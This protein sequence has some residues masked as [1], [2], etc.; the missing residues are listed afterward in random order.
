MTPEVIA[1]LSVGVSRRRGTRTDGV[2]ADGA[3]TNRAAATTLP[4]A[5]PGQGRA[6]KVRQRGNRAAGPGARTI[7]LALAVIMVA[8]A[9]P[10]PAW[11]QDKR[12]RA[13]ALLV[14][15]QK[16]IEAGEYGEALGRF[17]KAYALVPSPKIQYN[18]GLAY[19]GLDRPAEAMRSF[20]AF[21]ADAE[22][23]APA[24]VAKAREY[25]TKLSRKVGTLEF[26][27]ETAGAEVSIDGRSY[28]AATEV[29][30]DPGS[31]Q[32]TVDKSGRPPFLKRLT[33][34]P[35]ERLRIAVRFQEATPATAPPPVR[36]LP[37]NPVVATP[38][39]GAPPLV[40]GPAVATPSP[41]PAEPPDAPSGPTG[42]PWQYTA[43][44]VSASVAVVLLGGALAAGLM[45]N[46]K[47]ADFNAYQ[48]MPRVTGCYRS[49]PNYGGD[50]CRA[51]LSE[52]NTYNL[53]AWVGGIGGG[54]AAV[55]SVVFFVTAPSQ[56]HPET[57]L[58]CSPTLG[59]VG[60]TCRMAF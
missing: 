45:A 55:A 43:G 54:I 4:A 50:A 12:V 11:A 22:N 36:T 13:R 1:Y 58:N 7:A 3:L 57:A 53:L 20:Q 31:H 26:T 42:T 41:P 40:T 44:W 17:E 56:S 28:A 16:L 25:V 2:R 10:H 60:G 27:G 51:L 52:G 8:A 19:N 38:M 21:L 34:A 32:V 23:A 14:E 46:K 47:F 29:L 35:G 30:V 5:P 18:F 15:G 48:D 59:M 37:T 49:V 33:I 6:N 39:S 9:F 24:S